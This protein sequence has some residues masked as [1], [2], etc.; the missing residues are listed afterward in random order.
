[1]KR[2][3]QILLPLLGLFFHRVEL[4]EFWPLKLKVSDY[5]V[6]DG[7]TVKLRINGIEE[8]VRL[9]PID[10]PEMDQKFLKHSASA[11]EFSKK[12][13]IGELSKGEVYL[14]WGKRDMF[15]RLLGELWVGE[16]RVSETMIKKG[17]AF[18]YLFSQFSSKKEKGRWLRLQSLAQRKREGIWQYGVM[19]PYHYRKQKKGRPFGRPYQKKKQ[20]RS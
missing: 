17:C 2:L 6:L 13:L 8:R 11:G 20:N 9:I 14:Q 10:A 12:C 1:M 7:D 19:S 16:R 5:K 3:Y 4:T 15:G 18:L